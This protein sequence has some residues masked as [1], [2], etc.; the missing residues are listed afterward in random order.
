MRKKGLIAIGILLLLTFAG[1]QVLCAAE[2]PLKIGVLVPK[3]GIFADVGLTIEQAIVMAFDEAGNKVGGRPVELIIED[4]EAKVSTGVAKARKLVESDKVE[5]IIG[6]HMPSVTEALRD[7]CHKNE[8]PFLISSGG[9]SANLSTTRKSP[10]VLRGSTVSGQYILG[11]GTYSYDVLGY[12]KMIQIAPDYVYGREAAA[13]VKCEFEKAGGKVVQQM[14][15]PFATM[16]FAPYF[17]K[18]APDADVVQAEFAGADG[19]RFVQ[20]FKEY[21]LWNKYALVG[22]GIVLDEFLPVM[23]KAA[24]GIV[25][26]MNYSYNYDSPAAKKFA[27]DYFKRYGEVPGH[28]SPSAYEISKAAIMALD[29]LHGDLSD[30]KKFMKVIEDETDFMGP[31]GRFAFEKETNSCL[32]TVYIRK[33]VETDD[34]GFGRKTTFEILKVIPEVKP[35]DALRMLECGK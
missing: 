24:V 33:V 20:Q 34:D 3:A 30:K 6:T 31:R 13:V 7:Y 8:V 17:A 23:G 1:A 9:L 22:A 35:S 32:N 5:L 12:K 19:N 11:L 29:K 27:K 4:T 25:C 14:F 10:W 28:V 26:A 18:F 15:V 21:G 2:G 16:D